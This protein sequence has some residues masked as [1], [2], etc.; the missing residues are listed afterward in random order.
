M[1]TVRIHIVNRSVF[2]LS[3]RERAKTYSLKIAV[4]GIALQSLATRVITAFQA[5]FCQ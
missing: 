3:T 5:D 2:W 4:Y 1:K